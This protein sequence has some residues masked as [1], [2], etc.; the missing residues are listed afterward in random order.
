MSS[1]TLYQ[2][3]MR[4]LTAHCFPFN[5]TAVIGFGLDTRVVMRPKRRDGRRIEFCGASEIL[6]LYVLRGWHLL[7]AVRKRLLPEIA[8]RFQT[9]AWVFGPWMS[10][11][12][13]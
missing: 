13:V 5:R 6:S 8:V 11:M 2:K 7:D 3:G 4:S 9:V 10:R 1:L 12:T